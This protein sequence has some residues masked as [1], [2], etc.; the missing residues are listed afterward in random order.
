MMHIN[1]IWRGH[2]NEYDEATDKKKAF[3]I[4]RK[5]LLLHYFFFAIFV[6]YLVVLRHEN[7]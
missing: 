3:E 1:A 5:S 6:K 4:D 2:H 7:D